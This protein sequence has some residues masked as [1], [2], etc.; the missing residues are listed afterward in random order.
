MFIS[1]AFAQSAEAAAG[2]SI[3]SVLVQVGLIFVIFYFL[4]IRPQQK[5]IKQHEAMLNAIKKGDMVITGGGINA[6]VIDATDPVNLT[7]QIAD[8]IVV[9]VNRGTIREV[10]TDNPAF[11]KAAMKAA[12]KDKAANS[13][14]KVKSKK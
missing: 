12:K 10:L 3:S 9:S 13:N 1:D 11:D 14:Q 4:L 5:K 7:V 8:G 2:S 6:K